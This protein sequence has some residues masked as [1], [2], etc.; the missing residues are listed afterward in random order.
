MS[1][2]TDVELA[3]TPASELIEQIRRRALSPVELTEAVLAR[4]EQLQPRLFA[5]MTLDAEGAL[6]AART[7]EAAVMRGDDLGA[8]HGLPISIK[9]LEQTAG[10]RT[11]SGSKFFEHHV[12]TTD[13]AVAGL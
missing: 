10:L 9:D 1:P 4:A 3:F 13:G 12:P 5:F 11:T 7:A 6:A 8:L 2:S